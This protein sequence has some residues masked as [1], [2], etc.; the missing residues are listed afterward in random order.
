MS[1]FSADWLTLREPFDTA[2]LR[3]RVRDEALKSIAGLDP[4]SIVD[5]GCGTGSGMRAIAPFVPARQTW[6]LV[7]NDLSLLARAA[8][9][10]R[11]ERVQATAVPVDLAH[12]LEAALD[13][14]VDIVTTTALLDLVSAPWV[15]RLTVECA[16]RRL[17]LYATLSYNGHIAFT[18]EDPGDA[19]IIEA[20]NAHQRTDKGFGPALGPTAA[21]EAIARFAAVGY[22]TVHETSDWTIGPQDREMQN[23]LLA[24]WAGAAREIDARR[25]DEIIG[26]LTRRREMVAAG[27]SSMLVGHVDLF[28]RPMAARRAERSQSNSTSPSRR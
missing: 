27:R 1:G 3:A 28:A 22:V 24:G 13:G 12:D 5:L 18:P 20:V 2:A 17:P 8:D 9:S 4:V 25:L 21:A 26:W 16:A 15:E 7:D 19:A 14:A 23:A 6:R 11:P 10:P